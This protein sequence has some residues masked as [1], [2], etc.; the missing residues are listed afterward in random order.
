MEMRKKVFRLFQKRKS[1]DGRW[2]SPALLLLLLFCIYIFC[3]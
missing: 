3:F 2:K 1:A